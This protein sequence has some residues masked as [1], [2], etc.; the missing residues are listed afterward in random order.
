MVDETDIKLCYF[1]GSGGFISLHLLLLSGKFICDFDIN[2][3]L[4]EIISHQWSIDDAALWK[5]HETWPQN[6]KTKT[7]QTALR[8]IYFFCNPTDRELEKFQGI[9]ILVYTDIESQL[10]L[11]RYK[12]AMWCFHEHTSLYKNY[13]SFYRHKLQPWT[14]HYNNI[15]DASWPRCTGPGAF[16]QLPCWIQQELLGEPHTRASLDITRWQP[17]EPWDQEKMDNRMHEIRS[18]HHKILPDNTKVTEEVGNFFHN[19]DLSIKL[20]HIIN[21]P[22]TLTALTGTAWNSKQKKIRQQWINL[23][24][25][26]LLHTIGIR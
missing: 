19:A 21:D 18:G 15:K 12:R 26:A 3:N 16:K 1:G 5:S 11:A 10:Q 9:T 17:W 22:G 20:Q 14:A 23:H 6:E 13:V 8:K 24:S 25:P 7:L 2:L 4:D